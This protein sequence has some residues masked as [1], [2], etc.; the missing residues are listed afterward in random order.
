MRFVDSANSERKE[1]ERRRAIQIRSQSSSSSSSSSSLSLSLL[2]K[3]DVL[4]RDEVVCVDAAILYSIRKWLRKAPLAI[5]FLSPNQHS[6]HY[7]RTSSR[8]HFAYLPV[9]L[10]VLSEWTLDT[11]APRSDLNAK[12][13]KTNAETKILISPLSSRHRI[14]SPRNRT[15]WQFR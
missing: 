4:I 6:S 13:Q 2:L 11:I 8:S 15:C 1:R 14:S 12:Q 9:Q 3:Y 5:D 10:T 7:R